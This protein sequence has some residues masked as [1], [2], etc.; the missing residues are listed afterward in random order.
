[1]QLHAKRD[2]VLAIWQKNLEI[3]V[4]SEMEHNFLGWKSVCLA[5]YSS[6]IPTSRFVQTNGNHSVCS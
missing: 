2:T 3:S 1:M 5:D 4:E 6:V